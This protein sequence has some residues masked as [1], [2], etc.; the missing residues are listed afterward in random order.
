[1]NRFT[2]SFA[3]SSRFCGVKSCASIELERSIARTMLMPSLVMFS[4]CE[5]ERGRD[6]ATIVDA[7]SRLR[8]RKSMNGVRR[9]AR[10]P[11]AR[12]ETREN[13]IAPGGAAVE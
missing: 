8:K 3:T 12:T 7:S 13:T 6:S 2:T 4:E 9:P 5:P 1:M 10:G 11:L